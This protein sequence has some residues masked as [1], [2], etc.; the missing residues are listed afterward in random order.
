MR[1]EVKHQIEEPLRISA[2]VILQARS[3]PVPA[4]VKAALDRAVQRKFGR[5]S[6]HLSL[7]HKTHE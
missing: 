5:K 1:S 6:G 7:D 2:P 4:N 3:Y